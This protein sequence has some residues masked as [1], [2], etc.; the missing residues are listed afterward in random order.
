MLDA[1]RA[2][3]DRGRAGAPSCTSSRLAANREHRDAALDET[4]H[5]QDVPAQRLVP[6]RTPGP[7]SRT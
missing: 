3:L 1:V 2:E 4:Q 5:T 7:A 6:L